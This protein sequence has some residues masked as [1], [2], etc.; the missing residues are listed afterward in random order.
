MGQGSCGGF[1]GN[2][3]S[4]A[5]RLEMV[6]GTSSCLIRITQI[7]VCTVCLYVSVFYLKKK[8]KIEGKD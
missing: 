2:C 8:K 1:W 4:S 5:L 6:T 7:C 3:P